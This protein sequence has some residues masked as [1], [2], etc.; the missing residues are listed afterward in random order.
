MWLII[1]V[2]DV[3]HEKL[4]LD[5]NCYFKSSQRQDQGSFHTLNNQC[6]VVVRPVMNPLFSFNCAWIVGTAET[7]NT[8]LLNS[9]LRWQHSSE[10]I[11]LAYCW[12]VIPPGAWSIHQQIR[13]N[14]TASVSCGLD[15]FS[16]WT[17]HYH[18]SKII[19]PN[20]PHKMEG[21]LSCWTWKDS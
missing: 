17:R 15:T 19:A 21:M 13:R 16:S 8:F 9:H 11:S 12:V 18:F 6:N 2:Q 10:N 3:S 4:D 7:D 1:H 20:I 5:I 14:V